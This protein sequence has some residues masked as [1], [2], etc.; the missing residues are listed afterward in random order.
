[1]PVPS[2]SSSLRSRGVY[3]VGIDWGVAVA[4]EGEGMGPEWSRSARGLAD[5]VDGALSARD[6]L[7]MPLTGVARLLEVEVVIL[8]G[9]ATPRVSQRRRG[10]RIE[11]I[12]VGVLERGSRLYVGMGV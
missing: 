8:R 2:E 12:G 3:G 11:D 1:M 4:Y 9:E 7:R 5:G 10:N 6:S